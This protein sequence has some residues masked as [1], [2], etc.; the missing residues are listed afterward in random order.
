VDYYRIKFKKD[1]DYL[2]NEHER[3]YL[4]AEVLK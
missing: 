2:L 3:K 4:T 1:L